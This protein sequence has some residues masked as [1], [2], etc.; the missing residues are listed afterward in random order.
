MNC[1]AKRV[2][3]ILLGQGREERV[4]IEVQ[5][6]A[7]DKFYSECVLLCRM[8]HPN[9][10]QFMGIHYG[11]QREYG[12]ELTLIMESLHMDLDKCLKRYP[13]LQLSIKLSIL[14]DVSQ[15]LLH[16]HGRSIIHRDLTASN[17]LL[18]TGLQAKIAD[19]GVSKILN[20]HPLAAS[21]QSMI[22]GTLG[23]MPPEALTEQPQY[24]YAFDIFS[25]GVLMLYVVVQEYPQ[26]YVCCC[27]GVSPV[28]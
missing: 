11:K 16:L 28:L 27:P 25:F 8:R 3:D 22:P 21:K 5:C 17:V 20:V 12:H 24:I 15:G 6:A 1:I 18:T 23:Y 2:H 10:V 9:I 7:Y 13:N 26:Y 14:L 19:L 4:S